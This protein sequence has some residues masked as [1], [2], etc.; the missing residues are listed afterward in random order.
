MFLRANHLLPCLNAMVTLSTVEDRVRSLKTFIDRRVFHWSVG[1]T[2]PPRMCPWLF[3]SDVATGYLHSSQ[4]SS[5]EVSVKS[6]PKPRGRTMIPGRGS[7]KSC[8]PG[9]E[10]SSSDT[11]IH[12][13][14]DAMK[15]CQRWES[16]VRRRKGINFGS[17][18]QNTFQA[19]CVR[20]AGLMSR[21]FCQ[22]RWSK[23]KVAIQYNC[24]KERIAHYHLDLLCAGFSQNLSDSFLTMKKW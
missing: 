14:N 22:Y 2:E 24:L 8:P 12:E 23:E 3:H 4:A 1:P 5:L 18:V 16:T 10:K 6:L 11:R 19:T 7:L 17:C 20:S 13:L 21:C 9:C 15:R